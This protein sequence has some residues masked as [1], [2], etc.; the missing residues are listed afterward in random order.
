MVNIRP[1]NGFTQAA[2]SLVTDTIIDVINGVDDKSLR[3][4][5]SRTLGELRGVAV[6]I[7]GCCRD[8]LAIDHIRECNTEAGIS[9]TIGGH[10]RRT[11]ESLTLAK[12]RRIANTVR[13]EFEPEFSVGRAVE[14]PLN[15]RAATGC[16]RGQYRVVLQ[17]VRT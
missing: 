2:V 7:G 16:D 15:R 13:E 14:R 6:G 1:V 10:H 5:E 17:I 3:T 8:K 4:A 12:S 11:N 9:I